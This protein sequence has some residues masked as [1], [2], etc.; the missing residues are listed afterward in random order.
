[1]DIEVKKALLEQLRQ[2]FVILM[3]WI[4][5]TPGAQVQKQQSLLRFDEGH[6][7]MQNAIASYAPPAPAPEALQ[8]ELSA[9]NHES[10]TNSEDAKQEPLEVA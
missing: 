5:E 2:N 3:N 10:A 8:P 1:M 9:S 7:W 6:M 4:V